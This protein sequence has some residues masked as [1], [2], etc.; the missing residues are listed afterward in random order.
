M[1]K[2]KECYIQLTL[3]IWCALLS[4]HPLPPAR[5]QPYPLTP[6]AQIIIQVETKNPVKRSNSQQIA[7]YCVGLITQNPRLRE[8]D[9]EPSPKRGS[10]KINSLSPRRKNTTENK[11]YHTACTHKREPST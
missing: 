5:H 4:Q 2:C 7:L 3:G 6:S 9:L 1:W 11:S 10:D 8:E